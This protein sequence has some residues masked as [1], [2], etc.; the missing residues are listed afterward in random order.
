MK[1]KKIQGLAF[2]ILILSLAGV[3]LVLSD[4]VKNRMIHECR[5]AAQAVET[6]FHKSFDETFETL[7]EAIRLSYALDLEDTNDLEIFRKS[8][9]RL[10]DEDEHI[11]CAAY[12]NEDTLDYIYPADRFGDLTGKNMADF[13]YSITL[14]KVIKTPVVEGPTQLFDEDGAFF[15]FINPVYRGS[16]FIGEIVVALDSDYVLSA[17]GLAELESSN[18]D[19]ELW[20]VDFLGQSKT[21]I[22]VSDAAVD[23]SDA[24]KHEFNLPSTWNMS[25]KPKGGWIT[26]AENVSIDFIIL[27]LGLL[28]FGMG[29]LLY[30]TIC[31]Q[32]RLLV[33]K[34]TNADSG[35]LTIEGFSFF[36]NKRLSKHPES[37]LCMLELRLGN[38]RRFTKNMEREEF[39][40]HLMQL[41]QSITDCFPEDTIAASIN[42]DSFLL[43][44]FGDAKELERPV[45][46]FIL[47]MHWKRRVDGRKIFVTPRYCMVSYPEDGRD[48][49]SLI[50]AVSRQF[51]TASG[52]ESKQATAITGS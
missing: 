13:A 49:Q 2:G 15:L 26:H 41:R 44:I 32:R 19:Y 14:A 38:F 30:R 34:Y 46:D 16:D 45:E 51:E 12:F 21:V 36:V 10:V 48:V 35:L 47:Q 27:A 29:V 7:N 24:V 9:K 6:V 28:L 1:Y 43:A 18:Y 52:G 39:I 42:D 25:I 33:A 4:T 11:A 22:A 50:N 5:A 17:L 8:A 3:M 40:S 23:F 37:R 31:L 20:R